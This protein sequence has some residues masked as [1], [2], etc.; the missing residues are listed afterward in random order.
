MT[1]KREIMIPSFARAQ[2]VIVLATLLIASGLHADPPINPIPRAVKTTTLHTWDFDGG[3][4]GWVAENQC[5]LST[6]GGILR[7]QSTGND[8]FLHCPV[9]FPGGQVVLQLR[10]RSATSEPGQVF[11]TTDKFPHRSE[12]QRTEF[13]ITGDGQW[14]ETQAR[15]LA[16]GQLTDLRIDP[17]IN[18]GLV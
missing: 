5:S 7:V 9:D 3:E 16:P 2:L 12:A 1:K 13:A 11:W 10:V 18:P 4:S 15:L 14:H 8:P 6:D 17:S